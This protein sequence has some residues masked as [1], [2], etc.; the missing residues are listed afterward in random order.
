[1]NLQISDEGGDAPKHITKRLGPIFT[2]TEASAS[3]YKVAN[4]IIIFF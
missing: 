4:P 1:M 2:W 3:E